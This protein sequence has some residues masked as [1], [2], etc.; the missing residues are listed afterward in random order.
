MYSLSYPRNVSDGIVVGLIS[1]VMHVTFYSVFP[2]AIRVRTFVCK[3]DD[4]VVLLA[5]LKED[6]GH[7]RQS[8]KPRCWN[9]Y[10]AVSWWGCWHYS[11]IIDLPAGPGSH[12]LG[13]PG[14]SYFVTSM[15]GVSIRFW[16]KYM[17]SFRSAILSSSA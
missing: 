7:R 10:K 17:W 2:K 8:G 1:C 15:F 6:L 16:L 5:V 12:A 3:D 4:T 11:C 9:G 13:C 14:E